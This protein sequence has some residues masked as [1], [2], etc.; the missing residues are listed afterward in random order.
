MESSFVQWLIRVL[1]HGE[2]IQGGP[3]EFKPSDRDKIISILTESYQKYSLEIAGPP[4]EFNERLALKASIF[5]ASACWALVSDD[6]KIIPTWEQSPESV[7]DHLSVDLLFRF[8]PGVLKRSRLRDPDCKLCQTL[9]EVL[10]N[11]PLSGILADLEDKPATDLQ[12]FN[13]YGTQMLFAERLLSINR[14]EWVPKDGTSL[15]VAELV[16]HQ[17]NKQIPAALPKLD[18]ANE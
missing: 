8:L 11:W 1:E 13:H 17:R 3:P 18:F 16:F 9:V 4:V 5:L 12:F 6:V 10:C 2:S 7:S 14:V 15:Q